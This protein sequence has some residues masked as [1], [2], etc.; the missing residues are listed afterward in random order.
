MCWVWYI[1]G[2]CASPAAIRLI[3]AVSIVTLGMAVLPTDVRA[4]SCEVTKAASATSAS[5][6]NFKK[7]A[8]R[9]E[10]GSV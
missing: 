10:N 1:A 8:D 5:N 2:L 7:L 9:C 6:E 4:Q 3:G